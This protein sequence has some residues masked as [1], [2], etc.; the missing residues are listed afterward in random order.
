MKPKYILEIRKRCRSDSFYPNKNVGIVGVYSS[1]KKA[2]DWIKQY[3]KFWFSIGKPTKKEKKHFWAVCESSVDKGQCVLHG[4]YD[5]D[6]N[7]LL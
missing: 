1:S 4:F 7:V 3:A 2:Q 5:F 6:G